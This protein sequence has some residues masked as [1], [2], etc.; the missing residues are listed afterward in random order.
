MK[1]WYMY[2]LASKKQGVLYVWVT[3]DLVKRVYEHKSWFI[4]WFTRKYFV[5]NLVYFEEFEDIYVAI[6]REKQLK[7]G[8]RRKKIELIEKNNPDWEDLF[9]KIV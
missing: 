2:I 1:K 6:T 3:S 5:K 4:A 8:N 7:S 9:D